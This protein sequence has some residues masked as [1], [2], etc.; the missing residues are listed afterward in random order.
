MTT[1]SSE[2]TLDMQRLKQYACGICDTTPDQISHHKSHLATDKHQT[3]RELF[4]LQ[5]EQMTAEER[6]ARYNTDDVVVILDGI[7]TIA[8]DFILADVANGKSENKKLK[9]RVSPWRAFFYSR[10]SKIHKQKYT[11]PPEPPLI[12][13]EP[14]FSITL[15]LYE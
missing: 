13:C 15:P 8:T 14:L 5:V 10:H 9:I 1:E 4:R 7:E 12:G 2:L 11:A 6:T 3:K